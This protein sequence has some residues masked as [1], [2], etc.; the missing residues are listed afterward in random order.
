MNYIFFIIIFFTLTSCSAYQS[1]LEAKSQTIVINT[2]MVEGASCSLKDNRGNKWYLNGTPGAVTVKSG[3]PPLSIICSKTDYKKTIAILLDK[4]KD[5]M[6]LDNQ[7]VTPEASTEFVSKTPRL[8]PN[9]LEEATGFVLDPYAQI[10][11]QYPAEISIWMEPKTWESEQAKREWIFEK[12]VDENK[13]MVASYAQGEE[14][15]KYEAAKQAKK[16]ASDDTWEQR[17]EAILAPLK[18]GSEK[19]TNPETYNWFWRSKDSIQQTAPS[20]AFSNKNPDTIGSDADKPTPD[21]GF[22]SH[23]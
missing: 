7:K 2:P 18:Q 17:K 19:I 3:H 16:E 14:D 5:L 15:K 12:Q 13:S 11:T 6:K 1:A 8:V 4:K 10:S 21:A 9:V 22:Y 23:E 20:A